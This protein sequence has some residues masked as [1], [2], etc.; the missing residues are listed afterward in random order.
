[1]AVSAD[2]AA[3]LKRQLCG[4]GA[5]CR[6]A[7]ACMEHWIMERGRQ[8]TLILLGI[9]SFCVALILVA[10]PLQRWVDGLYPE[11]LNPPEWPIGVGVT[12]FVGAAAMTIVIFVRW[13]Y[14]LLTKEIDSSRR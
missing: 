14:L 7:L 5:L 9:W 1:M 6:V 2:V 8:T 11:L 10:F 13:I 12:G 3:P 4:K